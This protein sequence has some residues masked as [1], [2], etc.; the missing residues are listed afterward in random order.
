M[1]GMHAKREASRDGGFTLV[2]VLIVIVILGVLATVTV[3]AVRGISDRGETA[4]CQTEANT[5]VTAAEAYYAQN[6]STVTT[7][8][9]TLY[10]N[11][12]LR[13]AEPVAAW[14]LTD[15]ST[16]PGAVVTIAPIVDGRCDL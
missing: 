13:D 9:Q 3:F 5:V 1:N 2:E 11:G 7:S 8:I 12:Y 10:D 6:A 4:S 16:N 15:N 14:T